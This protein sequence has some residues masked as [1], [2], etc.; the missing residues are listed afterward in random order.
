MRVRGDVCA[1][2]KDMPDVCVYF[3]I[4]SLKYCVR[5]FHQM[6]A[7]N[8]NGCKIQHLMKLPAFFTIYVKVYYIYYAI[9]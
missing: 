4:L 2:A 6:Y 7:H 5:N 1:G 3:H 8:S 9:L